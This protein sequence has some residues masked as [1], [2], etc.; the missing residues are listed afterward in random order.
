LEQLREK[1]KTKQE[2]I[3]NLRIQLQKSRAN[4]HDSYS[5]G[6]LFLVGVVGLLLGGLIMFIAKK[7]KKKKEKK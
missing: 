4:H 5:L 3:K 2:E 1:L 6:I 7:K